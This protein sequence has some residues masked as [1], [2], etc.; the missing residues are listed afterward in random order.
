MTEHAIL[1]HSTVKLSEFTCCDAHSQKACAS[2]NVFS[3]RIFHFGSFEI[4]INS[5]F[6]PHHYFINY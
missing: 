6:P 1:E 2:M 5:L 3:P 4:R